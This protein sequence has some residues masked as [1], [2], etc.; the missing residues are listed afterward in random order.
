MPSLG[1][2]AAFSLVTNLL[3]VRL[4]PY[5]VFNFMIE[6]EGVLAGAFSE[7]SG[8][9]VETE[10]LEYREGGLNEYVHRFAGP[11]KYPPLVLKHGLTQIDGLWTWHQQV[12]QGTVTR[13]NGTI[14]LLDQQ[15]IP[16]MFWDFKE[17]YPVK[18]TGPELRADSGAVAF[19]SIELAHRG[20]SRPTLGSL[21]GGL[22]ASIS[23]S[24]DIGF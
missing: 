1:L 10:V 19:E 5:Q 3:G 9:G 16:V 4:D 2:N 12:V 23:G 15:R 21:L 22:S 20:L 17:A 6:I 24:V 14:Y 11:T 18:Y 7:C 8:L 13:Q